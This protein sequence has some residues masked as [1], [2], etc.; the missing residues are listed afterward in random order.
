MRPNTLAERYQTLIQE[1]LGLMAHIDEDQDVIF[2][3]PDLGSLYVRLDADKDPEYLMLVYPSFANQQSTGLDLVSA[4]NVVNEAN[5]T[6]KAAKAY[7]IP[8]SED[9]EGY[10]LSATIECFLAGSDQAPDP[11]LLKA[12]MARNLKALQHLVQCIARACKEQQQP[13]ASCH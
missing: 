7:L 10:R 4:L 13:R 8:R 5:R 1:E 9:E 11:A 3:H 12:V 2:R 6:C